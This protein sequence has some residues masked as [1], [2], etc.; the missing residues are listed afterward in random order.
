MRTMQA[1]LMTT[2]MDTNRYSGVERR[3]CDSAYKSTDDATINA[4]SIENYR[5]RNSKYNNVGK[6]ITIRKQHHGCKST[7]DCV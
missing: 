6:E 1:L 4:K 7:Q 3:R 5:Y 2:F